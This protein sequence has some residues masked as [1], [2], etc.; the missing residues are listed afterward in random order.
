MYEA[1]VSPAFVKMF[2]LSY[3]QLDH[4]ITAVNV[5]ASDFKFSVF[6]VLYGSNIFIFVIL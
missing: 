4:A 2:A 3:L 6:S 5:T 1:S